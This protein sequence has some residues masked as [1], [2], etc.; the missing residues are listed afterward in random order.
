MR[1]Y[2]TARK[3]RLKFT[4]TLC[5]PPSVFTSS[6]FTKLE[7]GTER[8]FKEIEKEEFQFED[9]CPGLPMSIRQCIDALY[10]AD[11]C[12][13]SAHLHISMRRLRLT[14]TAMCV[15]RRSHNLAISVF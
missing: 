13:Y 11:N 6:V 14:D 8:P 7:I 3:L 10:L 2:V 9:R 15:V 12:Q 1:Q 5:V 4:Y